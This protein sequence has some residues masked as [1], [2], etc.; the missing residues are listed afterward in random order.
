MFLERRPLCTLLSTQQWI[1]ANVHCWRSPITERLF[2][3]REGCLFKFWKDGAEP[4]KQ[5]IEL[6]IWRRSGLLINSSCWTGWW[7]TMCQVGSERAVPLAG[8]QMALLLRPEDTRC[9]SNLGSFHT[10]LTSK[11]HLMSS[12][13][14]NSSWWSNTASLK[15]LCGFMNHW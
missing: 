3:S 12:P 4:L 15:S 1:R 2:P 8:M 9:T 5:Q 7:E 11:S 13:D 6:D 10:H 14:L